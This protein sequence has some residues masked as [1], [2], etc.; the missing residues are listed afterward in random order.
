MNFEKYI[1][2]PYVEKGRDES[3]VDCYGL[4]RLIYKNELQIDLPSFSAEYT[5]TDTARIEELIAQ[6]KEGWEQTDEPVVGSIVLF[7]VFGNESHVG[8]VVS[9][10]H[11]I[12]VRE[13]Q[14]SVIESLTSTSWARR[15]VGYFNYSEKKSVVLNAVPHPLRTER[16]TMPIVPGTTLKVLAEGLT[17]EYKIAPELKSKVSVM[18]NGMV[19]PQEQWQDTILKEGDAVEY[20]AVPTGS[21]GR[22]LA[23]IAIAVIAPQIGAYMLQNA[24]VAAAAAGTTISAAMGGAI[25]FGTI[26][27][28]QLIG[29]ALVNAIAPIRPP[30]QAERN[31]PGSAERQL[32]VTGGANQQRPYGSIPVV[33]GKVR[34]TPP[35]GST[36]FLTYE[37]EGDSYISMLL[38]WGYGPMVID[39]ATLRIGAIPIASALDINDPSVYQNITANRITEL[40]A[41]QERQFDSIYGKDITQVNTQVELV[42][43][44]NPEVEVTPGPW[45][46][47]AT[48]V[49]YNTDNQIVPVTSATVALHFPQ[50]L[51]KIVVKGAESGASAAVAVNFRLE[52]SVNAGSSWTLLET[53]T[54]GGDTAKRNAFTTTKTYS[55]LNHGQMMI[56]VRRETGDNIED[57]PD[58]RYYFQA[59][60]QNVT[61]LRN[62]KPAVDPVGSKIAKSA[63]KI[64]ATNQ[65]NGSLQGI[66]AVVQTY[67]KIWNGTAWV[68][69]ATSNPA[70]LMRYVLEH[71]AN[72]RRITDA[73]SQI[74]LTQLQYFYNYCQ[75]RGFEYNGV[76]GE[77][78]S[79]L[80]V[81]RDICAAGRASPALVDGKWTVVIDEVKPNVIQHFT[82]HNSWGFEG[83]KALPKRPD[84]LRITFYDQDKDYQ[85][86][87]II[88]Y[89][90][91]KT[92]TSASLFESITLPGVTKR[93]LVIDHARWHM[94]QIKLRP[95]VYTINSD[96]EYL[97]CNRGDRVKVMH[98][99]PMWG[100]GSGRIKARLSDTKLLLDEDLP[101]KAGIT[102]TMRFRSKT[103]ESIVRNLVAKSIDGYYN[104]VDLTSSVTTAQADVLDLFLFGELQQEAQD[105]MVISIEPSANNSARI[106][107]VDYGVT[108]E[109]NIFTDY[110]N[111][112]E[113]T[114]FESQITLPP[115]LQVENFGTKTPLITGFVSD[116]S[117]MERVSKGVFRFKINVAFVNASQ[118]PTN[119]ESVE[120]QY[121]LL[122]STV[123]TN[124]RSVFV[125]Y[126]NGSASIADVKESETYKVRMRYVGRNGVVGNWTDYSNHTVVGKTNPPSSVTNFVAS[127]DK[128]SGQLL[129]TWTP[130]PEPDVYTY[131]IR[132]QDIG[133]GTDDSSRL[134]FGDVTKAFIKY[135]ANGSMNL[136]IRAVDT[137]GNYSLASTSQVFIAAAV[138]NVPDIVFNYAN[139]QTTGSSVTLSWNEV[140]NSQFDIDHYE[141]SY[142]LVT[143]NVK[144]STLTVPVD[145]IGDKTF[146]IKTVDIYQKKSSGYSETITKNLPS[147]VTGFTITA[148]KLSGQLLLSWNNNPEPDVSNYE[149]RTQDNNWGVNDASRLFFGNNDHLFTTYSGQ[150]SV[151]LYIRS[152]DFYNNYTATTVTQT[153]TRED[154]PNV[155]NI[156]YSYS[157]TSLTSATVTLTWPN[158]TVSQFD[159]AFYEVIYN[160][161]VKTVKAN[162]ITIAADWVGD[163]LFTIKVV[164]VH[165][166]KSSGY[167]EIVTK[168]APNSP[169]ELRA[170]VVDNTV[171]LYW[172]LPVRTSLPIDHIL[173]KR[174]SSWDTAT[175]LGDKKG[176]FTTINE[177]TG[178]NFT[179]WLAAVDTEGVQSTPVSVTTLVSEPPDFVFHGEFN[180][181]FTGTKSAAT[182]DGSVLAIPVNTSE[183]FEQHFTT[184]SWSTPQ[185]QVNAGYP[186][187]IQPSGTTGYYEEVFDF[188]QPLA[189]SRVL[190]TYDGAVIAGDP[191]IVPKISLSLDNSTYIDYNGVNDVFGL[192]FRYVKIRITVTSSP[193]NIG[194]YEIVQLTLRLDAKLKNDAGS[195]NAV[196]TDTLGTIVNFNKEFIDVQSLN[197]SPSGTTP[198][199]PVYDIKDTFVSGTYSVSSGVCTVSINNH[200]MIT[201]QN[202]KLFINSGSGTTDIF[203]VTSYSTNSFTVNMPVGNTSGSCS[204]Y[205]QSFRVYLFNN[206]GTRVSANAS[207]SIKGY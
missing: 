192:N 154:V 158:I 46:E 83:T 6:Y 3:G 171:M 177:S 151:T 178:G 71:P 146:T 55:N 18:V 88:V 123:G 28:V 11:F 147:A 45:F 183:T 162:N 170:Q 98:D 95:E 175:V 91:G 54:I 75:T 201:G 105:L 144:A 131:E 130:N 129:V 94:A 150:A 58:L 202:I 167:S 43:D 168:L 1:G 190:L 101:M 186:I 161:I 60:L 173:I 25:Y 32:L 153:F 66:S 56:R 203:T 64:K 112:T 35:L 137:S 57:N 97:V 166:N 68:D 22:M 12:H 102:Y 51:R 180:S 136:F 120:V 79:I 73:A 85:E 111:L 164:D 165:G 207:W 76:L 206:S 182:F 96:I 141:V 116:E 67:C 19:I 125:P 163:R 155:T 77:A 119:V 5:Q 193:T 44:G 110:Q 140:V 48:G 115:A 36:N 126:Q 113:S 122:D 50:G 63:F 149:I 152:V 109:Y 47:A 108:P 92:I 93:S 23:M 132:T 189:S 124:F 52:Y 107:L 114:V 103:G 204:M 42:C 200:G 133:W 38:V 14:D 62:N 39:A 8:V 135:N 99:V 29:S 21:A 106:T 65:L 78:R 61:F 84:G 4:V 9:P 199:I 195:V 196:S 72:P 59:I 100:L 27:A 157:D 87:E 197:V 2:I 191:T 13:N 89:D 205:P 74:N 34:V 104:E 69:G 156:D 15:K 20:R 148:D 128:S 33:L 10:T 184:R 24:A 53:L 181:T 188:G 138:P 159:L 187:F 49:E 139:S 40:T 194:L 198:I 185:D 142:G 169:T 81:I 134:F 41:D 26:A 86:S 117:V 127:A 82:P 160:G 90:I 145:W 174:G 70:A 17:K 118:L 31:D 16:Y 172:T 7:R 179:Y 37:N 30:V 143:K 80:E 176:E 121:D